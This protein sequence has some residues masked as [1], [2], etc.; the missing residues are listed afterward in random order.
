VPP[1][2]APPSTPVLA[3]PTSPPPQPP[4]ASATCYPLS[5]SGTCYR[6]GEFCRNSDHGKAGRTADGQAI[7]CRNNNGWRWEPA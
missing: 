5:N 6:P 4:V 1:A 3:V 2:S 7:I